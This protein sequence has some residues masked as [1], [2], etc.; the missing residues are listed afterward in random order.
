MQISARG[1]AL[2]LD[3]QGPAAA[4]PL[5]LIQGLGMQLTDWPQGL[6]DELL[7]HGLRVIRYDHRDVGLSQGFDALG[8]PN[9]ALNGFKHLFHL[10]PSCT[11]T[12]DDL[13]DDAVALLDALGIAQAHLV[14]ASLGGMVAQRLAARWPERVRSLTLVMTTAGARELPQPSLRVAGLLAQRAPGRD[15]ESIARHLAHV[16]EVLGSPAYR[17]SP[18]AALAHWRAHVQRAW[19]PKGTARQM[20]AVVADGDRTPLLARIQA[21]THVIHGAA[22][23]LVPVAAAHHLARHIRGATLDVI[24]GMGHDFPDAL[25]PRWAAGI[26]QNAARS[27]KERP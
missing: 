13:A 5:L 15:T 19:R 8:V 18:E 10:A 4:P 16:F 25:M 24:D 11:Y 27:G 20:A 1:I 22:D 12:L 7:Q 14:G 21:P 6:L 3:D 9:P 23:P 17:P 26:A 2:E